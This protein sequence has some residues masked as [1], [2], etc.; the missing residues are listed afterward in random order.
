MLVA[1]RRA[2]KAT[3][4]RGP[5]RRRC[6]P[7][8]APAGT[9]ISRSPS[10]VGHGRAAPQH[11]PGRGQLDHGDQVLT[12]ALE[13]LV[14]GDDDL[15][16]EVAGPPAGLAGMPGAGDP[17]PLP[18]LDPRRDLDLPG[19]RADGP[20]LASALR[21]RLL[22]DPALAAAGRAGAGAHHLTERGARDLAELA[23]AA[24][25]LAGADRRSGLG[26]VPPAALAGRDRLERHLASG[27]RQHLLEAHL[28]PRRRRRRRSPGP[29]GPNPN[30]SPNIGSPRPKNADSTSSKLP[31]P[32]LCGAQPPERRPSW[33]K[34]S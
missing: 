7:G 4:G 3:A 31:K 25:R 23:A 6:S 28:D 13:P 15:D 22:G 5:A 33:P 9:S 14:L 2:A 34:V 32:S 1:S 16:V 20:A 19:A 30:M 18:G 29:A 8:W 21:A 26:A 17:D 12:V 24:T 10:S 11:R 27:A